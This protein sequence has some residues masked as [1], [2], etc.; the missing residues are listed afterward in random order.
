LERVR[1]DLIAVSEV[2]ILRLWTIAVLHN[3]HP[4]D[5]IQHVKGNISQEIIVLL[6]PGDTSTTTSERAENQ[7]F[8]KISAESNSDKSEEK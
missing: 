8:E 7:H 6:T 1:I 3:H 5:K 4:R 2:H